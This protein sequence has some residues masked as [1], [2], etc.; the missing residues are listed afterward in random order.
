MHVHVLGHVCGHVRRHGHVYGLNAIAHAAPGPGASSDLW[1]VVTRTQAHVDSLRYAEGVARKFEERLSPLTLAAVVLGSALAAVCMLIYGALH[2]R[3]ARQRM[4]TMELELAALRA[5][6]NE[7]ERKHEAEKEQEVRC[8]RASSCAWPWRDAHTFEL[9]SI[10]VSER[11][12]PTANAHVTRR[13][14]GR[15]PSSS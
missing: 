15:R 6:R 13:R 10:H 14:A 2:Y 11:M 3:N 8:S 5:F 1:L 9:G 7:A 12:H 4:T